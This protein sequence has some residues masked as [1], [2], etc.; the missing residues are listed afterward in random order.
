VGQKARPGAR[1]AAIASVAVGRD[2]LRFMEGVN[3]KQSKT[4]QDKPWRARY[5]EA[6]Q[7]IEA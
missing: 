6:G 7:G 5:G 2:A 1:V 3:A 4:G